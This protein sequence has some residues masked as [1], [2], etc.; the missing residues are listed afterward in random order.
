MER[1]GKAKNAICFDCKKI[2]AKERYEK[3]KT[4][5]VGIP[6]PDNYKIGWKEIKKRLE[7]IRKD[8]LIIKQNK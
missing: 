1:T 4:G 8:N 6:K 3:R 2:K 5:D 7:K